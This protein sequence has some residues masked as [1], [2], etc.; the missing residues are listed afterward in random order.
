ML[1]LLKRI[2]ESPKET[3][4]TPQTTETVQNEKITSEV[5]IEPTRPKT[6]VKRKPIKVLRYVTFMGYGGEDRYGGYVIDTRT[7][8]KYDTIVNIVVVSRKNSRRLT[9]PVLKWIDD[10]YC[11]TAE[12]NNDF[13]SSFY[14]INNWDIATGRMK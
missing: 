4:K 14:D 2:F 13:V 7:V 11:S 5:I 8:E 6:P 10:S 1:K 12:G 9:E 3:V